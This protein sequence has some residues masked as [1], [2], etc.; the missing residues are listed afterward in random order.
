[1]PS[2][3]RFS[4]TVT[5]LLA[6]AGTSDVAMLTYD[7]VLGRVR[8]DQAV[9]A[10]IDGS[11]PPAGAT[12]VVERSSDLIQWT[13]VRGGDEVDVDPDG[14]PIDDFEFDA[15]VQNTYRIRVFIAGVLFWTFR[16]QIT[17]VLDRPWLKSIA[18]PFLN[19]E[20][21]ASTADPITRPARGGVGDVVGRSDAVAV[22]DVRASGRY[23]LTIA[24]TTATERVDVEALFA[25]GDVVLLQTP[26]NFRIPGG[27]YFVGDV[28]EDDRKAADPDRRWW[29]LP[30][31]KVAAPA[32]GIVGATITWRGLANKY[33]SW[34][35]VIAANATWADVLELT[36]TADDVVVP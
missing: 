2:V 6:E 22:T 15:N 16:D 26:L 27:Y 14:L 13:T 33:A 11:P 12:R 10:T 17:V 29:A 3:E 9:L 20:I 1:M 24:T 31:T 8:V 19:R 4:H 36:G 30:L 34:N 21:T 7:P 18:Y 5:V 28:V 32:A 35:D 23:T 25:P